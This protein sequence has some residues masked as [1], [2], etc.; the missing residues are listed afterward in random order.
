MD[1]HKAYEMVFNDMMEIGP[2]LFKGNYDSKN[3][4]KN[5]M[6]GIFTVMEFI[7][8]GAGKEEEFDNV[9]IKNMIKNE[10]RA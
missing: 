3:G 8:F 9:F 5:F 10:E 1:L 4:N 2:N 6:Y 7:A